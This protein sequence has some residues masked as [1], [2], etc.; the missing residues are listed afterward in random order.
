MHAKLEGHMFLVVNL[1]T[2]VCIYS[3]AR[4][5]NERV[6]LP[7]DSARMLTRSWILIDC[8]WVH[9]CRTQTYILHSVTEQRTRMVGKTSDSHINTITIAFLTVSRVTSRYYACRLLLLRNDMMLLRWLAF[10]FLRSPGAM[11][12]SCKKF[13]GNFLMH[14]GEYK[15]RK[16]VRTC[17]VLCM[18]D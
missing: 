11:W 13:R 3:C 1:S 4:K 10:F 9:E 15:W 18:T 14:Q 6:C 16:H 5:L 7:L 12:T 2:V 8:T 17:I